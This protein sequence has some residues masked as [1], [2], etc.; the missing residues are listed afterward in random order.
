MPNKLATHQKFP[1]L[2][3]DPLDLGKTRKT[4]GTLYSTLKGLLR[5]DLHSS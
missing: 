2:K 3:L 4:S 1:H 5:F